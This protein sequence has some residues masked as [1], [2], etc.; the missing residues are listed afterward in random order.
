MTETSEE[1]AARSIEDI[2]ARGA[3]GGW[4]NGRYVSPVEMRRNAIISVIKYCI[5]EYSSALKADNSTLHAE[6]AA[7]AADQCHD[8]YGDEYGNHRCKEID[9]LRAKLAAESR[10]TVAPDLVA[11]LKEW[12][13]IWSGFSDFETSRRAPPVLLDRIRR[14]RDAIARAE[15]RVPFNAE[16]KGE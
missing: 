13:E 2:F 1:R 14:S 10:S 9:D 12:I 7:L 6:T 4:I 15:G 3:P 11:A 8:G 16:S 5:S